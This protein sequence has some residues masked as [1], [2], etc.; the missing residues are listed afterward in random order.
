MEASGSVTSRPKLIISAGKLLS[1]IRTTHQ[2]SKVFW[3]WKNDGFEL[4]IVRPPPYSPGLAKFKLSPNFWLETF[5]T[6]G[7]GDSSDRWIFSRLQN[8]TSG[9][10][11]HWSKR[12]LE[13]E[14]IIFHYQAVNFSSCSRISLQQKISGN[15]SNFLFE[16]FDVLNHYQ[17]SKYLINVDVCIHLY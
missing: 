10:K 14:F 11:V 5:W 3:H 8:G 2:P 1:R 9:I 12:I 17:I 15:V 7:R 6:K 4:W 16:H 13:L